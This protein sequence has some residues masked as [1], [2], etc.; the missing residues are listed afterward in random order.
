MDCGKGKVSH[1]AGLDGIT[2]PSTP[3]TNVEKE[4]INKLTRS[5]MSAAMLTPTEGPVAIGTFVLLLRHRGRLSGGS[6]CAGC[7]SD[8][9][10]TSH[11]EGNKSEYDHSRRMRMPPAGRDWVGTTVME[12]L[13]G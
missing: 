12:R 11:G 4:S 10:S 3:R 1:C 5:L 7:W 9:G 8:R 6:H 13:R 2:P